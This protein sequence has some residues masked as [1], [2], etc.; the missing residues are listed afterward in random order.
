[1][2]VQLGTVVPTVYSGISCV[3]LPSPKGFNTVDAL[4]LTNLSTDIVVLNNISDTYQGQELLM[5]GQQMVYKSPNV[6]ALPFAFGSTLSTT[7]LATQL[8]AEWS[9]DSA[10]DF[11][12]TYPWSTGGGGGGTSDAM[13][14]RGDYASGNAYD[15]NDV[16][17]NDN[18]SWIC[19]TPIAGGVISAFVGTSSALAPN[20]AGVNLNLPTGAA[21]G[22][23]AIIL[24]SV[25]AAVIS[26]P[27]GMTLIG[28][29][30]GSFRLAAYSYVLQASD[31]SLGHLVLPAQAGRWSAMLLD[32]TGVA[33][34]AQFVQS[35]TTSTTPV[36]TPTQGSCFVVIAVSGS[37]IA[38]AA[39]TPATFAPAL[40]NEFSVPYAGGT[41]NPA[42]SIW[43]GYTIDAAG[44][45]IGPTV[46]T[47][48]GSINGQ[49]N[50]IGFTLLAANL[51]GVFPAGNF[52]KLG[53]FV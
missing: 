18:S 27:S 21:A 45:P 34:G 25:P 20:G 41:G 28:T 42:Q 12:G 4:R 23:I 2:T 29:S 11:I 19:T 47:M 46:A 31:I 7:T 44:S 6:S 43:G 14:Y 50:A 36:I 15:L 38:T 24:I 17:I 39:P 5:P 40:G 26:T 8:Y 9:D 53:D 16:V 48:A 22:D 51:P 10:T 3:T 33:V 49:P 1:M 37:Y 52:Q 13:V 32:Y 30:T 35:D